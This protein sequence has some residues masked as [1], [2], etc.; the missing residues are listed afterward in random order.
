MVNIMFTSRVMLI[1]MYTHYKYG[2]D[3]EA[4]N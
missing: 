2:S 3:D 4:N 1:K